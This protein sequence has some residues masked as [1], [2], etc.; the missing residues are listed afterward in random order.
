MNCGIIVHGP[1]KGEFVQTG[2]PTL[3]VEEVRAKDLLNLNVP[4][5]EIMKH[6]E[7]RL[8]VY[9]VKGGIRTG[10]WVPVE[11]SDSDAVGY[12]TQCVQQR[13][14]RETQH[15]MEGTR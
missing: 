10:I 6:L 11:W 4:T 15:G 12:L 9:D 3:R 13:V 7:Y 5:A 8:H 14:A 2:H 1:R